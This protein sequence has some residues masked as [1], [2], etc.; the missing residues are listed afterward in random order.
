MRTRLNLKLKMTWGLFSTWSW[1]WFAAKP[2]LGRLPRFEVAFPQVH[3][4][5]GCNKF[6]E[7]QFWLCDCS[8]WQVCPTNTPTVIPRLVFL[9]GGVSVGKFDPSPPIFL[10]IV[11]EYQCHI[12]WQCFPDDYEI[13]LHV[14]QYYF[15]HM[16]K[17]WICFCCLCSRHLR[18]YLK[19]NVNLVQIYSLLFLQEFTTGCCHIASQRSVFPK[20]WSQNCSAEM[21]AIFLFLFQISKVLLKQKILFSATDVSIEL[22]SNWGG[23]CRR[24]FNRKTFQTFDS[25]NIDQIHFEDI[26]ASNINK[27]DLSKLS[28]M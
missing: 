23:Q 19:L 11:I 21:A 15:S 10:T 8:I 3:K 12:Y 4:I 24:N 14:F 22:G 28:M 6:N 25:A 17:Q 9:G 1:R 26:F 18:Q 27:L 5:Q 13:M 2:Q 20:Y 16:Q 7:I